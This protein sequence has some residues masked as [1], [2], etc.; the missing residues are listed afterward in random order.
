MNFRSNVAVSGAERSDGGRISKDSHYWLISE[1]RH[2]QTGALTPGLLDAGRAL[3]VFSFKEEAGM[4]LR[5]RGGASMGN[6][7]V[8]EWTAR[9]LLPVLLDPSC[10]GVE[11]VVL[12]PIADVTDAVSACLLGVSKERFIGR[13]LKCSGTGLPSRQ[14]SRIGVTR[15]LERKRGYG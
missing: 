3:P 1:P 12:D 11:K 9:D 5:A 7:T 13:L 2:A 4:F 15:S 10:V 14:S 6:R 8:Q